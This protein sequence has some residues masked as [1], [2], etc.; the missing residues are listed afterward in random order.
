MRATRCGRRT[1]PAARPRSDLRCGCRSPPG[2]PRRHR[3]RSPAPPAD[4]GDPRAGV[5]GGAPDADGAGRGRLRLSDES[6]ARQR[7]TALVP[8]VT[9][10]Q[11][12]PTTGH[13]LRRPDPTDRDRYLR[14]PV[15]HHVGFGAPATSDDDVVPDSHAPSAVPAVR[16]GSSAERPAGCLDRPDSVRDRWI[17]SRPSW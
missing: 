1:H 13:E 2:A 9:P 5:V 8:R 10:L 7:G 6:V 16:V 17:P 15:P 12:P 11:P 3:G 4:L 14:L